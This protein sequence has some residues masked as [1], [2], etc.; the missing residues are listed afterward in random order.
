MINE[1]IIIILT[2]FFTG[3]VQSVIGVGILLFGT[4][5]LLLIGFNYFDVLNILL[6]VSL[7]VNIFQISNR[8][9]EID[10]NLSK[11]LFILV[12]P[13][14]AIS[15]TFA[16]YINFDFSVAIGF[17][18]LFL[19]ISKLINF[20]INALIK[21]KMYLILMAIIHGITNLGG[22][23]LTGYISIKEWDKNKTRTNIAF[24]YL[25]FATTQLI[26][27]TINDKLQLNQ[28]FL[29][30]IFFG[31]II[32]FFTNKLIFKNIKESHFSKLI[33]LLLLVFGIILLTRNLLF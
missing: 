24:C 9:K 4:P 16:T 3:I 18:L 12:L 14:V 23:L 31:L 25:A 29:V 21:G 26:T 5:I 8:I 19:S 13:F 28:Y 11:D 20:N 17:F 22:S 15:L 33:S 1:Q 27:L 30:H 6:P 2:L 32:F 10:K 7:A